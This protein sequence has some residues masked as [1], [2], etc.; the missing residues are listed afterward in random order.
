MG[1]ARHQHRDSPGLDAGMEQAL[2]H[3][4]Q[5]L[6]QRDLSRRVGDEHRD[7]SA[8]AG[9]SREGRP[10]DRVV[11][12]LRGQVPQRGDA[13]WCGRPQLVA[14]QAAEVRGDGPAPVGQAEDHRPILRRRL[15][16]GRR[17][18]RPAIPREPPADSIRLISRQPTNQL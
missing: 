6:R 9:T 14:V 11:E 16:P 12:R 1:P 5:D 2:E 10:L 17:A 4:W 3:Q 7:A 8:P 18:W 13:S 15:T